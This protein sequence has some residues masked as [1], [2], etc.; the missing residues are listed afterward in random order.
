M[1]SLPGKPLLD[2]NRPTT[3][4][5]VTP[6]C[7][8]GDAAKKFS[9]DESLDSNDSQL[10]NEGDQES[11]G[12]IS[13]PDLV[14]RPRSRSSSSSIDCSSLYNH[15]G[16]EWDNKSGWSGT[17]NTLSEIDLNIFHKDSSGTS[18]YLANGDN[19]RFPP[20]D[21]H[22]GKEIYQERRPLLALEPVQ[23]EGQLKIDEDDG[24]DEM[25]LPCF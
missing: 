4:E 21:N 11:S 20:L 19:L 24:D 12:A 9:R 10:S 16:K 6:A 23:S 14:G 8:N 13:I 22:L 3:Q 1:P 18:L 17:T 15:P 7:S 5:Q 25:A 2:W